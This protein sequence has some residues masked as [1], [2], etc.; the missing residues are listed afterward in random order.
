MFLRFLLNHE[1]TIKGADVS[2]AKLSPVLES[3]F[4]DSSV[5]DYIPSA[6]D[7]PSLFSPLTASSI[8]DVRSNF[9][10]WKQIDE[11]SS[12][13][14]KHNNLTSTGVFSLQLNH[15]QGSQKQAKSPLFFSHP[16]WGASGMEKTKVTGTK[17]TKV[18][19]LVPQIEFLLCC[20]SSF[21]EEWIQL[22]FPCKNRE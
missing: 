5:P 4:S 13:A 2:V 7:R 19:I 11:F 8:G 22:M 15:Q 9:I 21:C 17:A 14:H 12:L 6:P 1:I 10:E 20:D 3:T 18:C 16:T